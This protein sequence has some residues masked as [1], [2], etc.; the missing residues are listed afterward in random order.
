LIEIIIIYQLISL[1]Y[2]SDN[3]TI[4]WIWWTNVI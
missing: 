2:S 1:F 3:S 4:N